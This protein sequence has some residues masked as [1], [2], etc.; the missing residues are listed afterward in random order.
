MDIFSI[1]LKEVK[2]NIRNRRSMTMMVLFPIILMVVLGTA[3]AGVFHSTD[4]F[5]DID[6]IYTNPDGTPYTRLFETFLEKGG[7][8]GIKFTGTE[9]A[10]V[11]KDNIKGGKYACFIKVDSKG[12]VLYKNNG[13]AM[14]AGIVE[15]FLDS[16]LQRY[17]AITA[18]A[19]VN[20]A[21]AG[22]VSRAEG[23]TDYVKTLTLGSV[24]TPGAMDYYAVSMLTLIVLY[25]SI[26]GTSA[27]VNEK[28]TKTANRILSSPVTKYEFLT[29]KI[30]GTVAI[31][32]VQVFIVVIFS[33]VVLKSYWGSHMGTVLAIVAAE[34]VMA[35][36]L[37]LGLAFVLK[38]RVVSQGILNLIIP[39]IAFL[40]GGYV[41]VETFGKNMLM[42]SEI[43]PLR[44]V[45][46]AIFEIIYSNDFSTVGTAI[47]INLGIAAVFVVISAFG[48]RREAI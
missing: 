4:R 45:N 33:K 48:I 12:L 40:G 15:A 29:G 37:G 42:L 31:T 47:L 24:K 3:L 43:S 6:V 38:D 34:V 25:A 44:W 5:K 1:L 23:S 20:P 10:K 22:M 36:S 13:N 26:T 35:V 17:S 32:L 9:N 28:T 16:F 8:M 39:V 27:I 2:Q 18:I 7:E 41:P 21:A 46:K 19:G 11:G 30:L 14:K